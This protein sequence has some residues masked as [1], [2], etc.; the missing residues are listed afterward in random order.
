M[1]YLHDY[2]LT[3]YTKC[4]KCESFLCSWEDLAVTSHSITGVVIP[5][6]VFGGYCILSKTPVYMTHYRWPLFNMHFWSCFVDILISALITPYLIFPAVAGFPVGLLQFLE[7]PVTVQIWFG[8]MGIYVMVMSMTIL[9]ENRHNSI[10]SNRFRI[11]GK[12]FKFI[13]Y[14]ARVLIAVSFSMLI[15]QFVPEDQ[16]SALFQILKSIPCPTEEFFTASGMF[17]LVIDETYINL[18]AIACVLGVSFEILQM[19]FFIICCLHYLYFAINGFTSK[20]TR[21]LQIAFFGSIMLQVSIPILFLLPSFVFLVFSVVSGYYNQALTN[22]SVVYASIH[23]LLSTLVVLT[24][25]KPYRKFIRSLLGMSNAV[26]L[27]NKSM[28]NTR[29]ASVFPTHVTA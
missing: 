29:K 28:F 3:N 8:I 14:S 21:K 17:V 1:S 25:H 15:F 13:Y 24:I 20:K 23:G 11:T 12:L 9:L 10:P 4:S 22:F 18:L 2:Y 26:D 7:I 16:S 19:I 6:H 27:Q 5:F